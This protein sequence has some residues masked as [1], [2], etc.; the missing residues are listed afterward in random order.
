MCGIVGY[1]GPK[2]ATDVVLK[3]LS[4]LEYRGYDS[5]GVALIDQNQTGQV[6]KQTVELKT[7]NP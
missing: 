7:S 5:V 2:Q 1:L 6:I 4:A 3:G